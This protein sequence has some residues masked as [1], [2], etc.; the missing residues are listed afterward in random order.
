MLKTNTYPDLVLS[1]K[2]LVYLLSGR[3][4]Y[5]KIV[6]L[7]PQD[8]HKLLDSIPVNQITEFKYIFESFQNELYNLSST[9]PAQFAPIKQSLPITT[10]GITGILRVYRVG[11]VLEIID[12]L[13]D[14]EKL[15]F[16]LPDWALDY[17]SN[18][19]K[20]IESKE[21]DDGY[22]K[23]DSL[24]KIMQLMIESYKDKSL[25]KNSVKFKS[26]NKKQYYEEMKKIL[27]PKASKM[28]ITYIANKK[29]KQGLVA[30]KL[31]NFCDFIQ[32][33]KN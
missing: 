2:Q 5:Q 19:D 13:F 30:K 4:S 28:G 10:R 9:N 15:K 32:E 3:F 25:Q 17:L 20:V 24:P 7:P 31:E 29:D 12:G 8:P 18:K 23:I 21:L 1:I 22:I 14:K 16:K 11:D 33:D 26:K 6:S 27:N